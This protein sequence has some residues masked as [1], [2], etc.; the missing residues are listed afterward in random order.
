[1]PVLFLTGVCLESVLSHKASGILNAKHVLGVGFG[2]RY[3][4]CETVVLSVLVAQLDDLTDYWL[5]WLATR[6]KR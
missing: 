1:M 4:D 3:N 6:T 2:P 5:C